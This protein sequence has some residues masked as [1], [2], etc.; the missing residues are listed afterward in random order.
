MSTQALLFDRWYLSESHLKGVLYRCREDIT[1]LCE[2]VGRNTHDGA[3]IT[4]GRLA[5]AVWV[6]RKLFATVLVSRIRF[7]TCSS[8][9][10]GDFIPAIRSARP[11]EEYKERPRLHRMSAR[12][13][14]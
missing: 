10:I 8:V 13:W 4:A 6:C 11:R 9:S 7:K 5:T 1:D 3:R 12:K 14:L 2:S